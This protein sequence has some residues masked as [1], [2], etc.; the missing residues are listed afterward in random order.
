M[1]K[2]D[3]VGGGWSMVGLHVAIDDCGWQK[4]FRVEA[5]S[6]KRRGEKKEKGSTQGTTD[7]WNDVGAVDGF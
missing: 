6:R 4:S 2:Y 1:Q 3:G 5:C 7:D